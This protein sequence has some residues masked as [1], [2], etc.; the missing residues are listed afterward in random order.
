M[1]LPLS[2]SAPT[3]GV[4]VL[5]LARFST[6][7]QRSSG[8]FLRRCFTPAELSQCQGRL[9]SLAGRWAAKEAVIKCLSAGRQVYRR[10]IE[11]LTDSSGAPQLLLD[12]RPSAI[13][14][15]ISHH[16]D[17][18]VAVALAAASTLL[19]DPPA[20]LHLPQ[21]PADAHKGSFGTVVA[22]AGSMGYTG[23]AHLCATAAA[24]AGAGLVRLLVAESLHGILAAKCTEVMA[25][26]VP[27]VLPGVIGQVSL[28]AMMRHLPSAA[29]AVVGPGLGQDTSTRRAVAELAQAIACPTVL[30]ADALNAL[31]HQA[32]SLGRW[33]GPRVLTPHP[34][35]MARLTGLTVQQ[36]QAD[37]SEIA[38]RYARQWAAV[39]ALKG[40]NT[41][42]ARPDGEVWVD[43]HS[44]PALASAG[45]GD[46]LAGLIAGL[47]AQGC[48]PWQAAVTGVFVHA[49]AGRWASLVMG[50][51][52]VLASD[53]LELIPR[54]MRAARM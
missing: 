24:R 46:V 2:D 32:K 52:G 39:V 37:R 28:G 5:S 4:D 21:R 1:V 51:S 36:I 26:P 13:S 42:V 27:E 25:T 48:D 20:A 15:S 19:A 18:V 23:A 47:M 38:F 40:A 53:L 49:E 22:I 16:G 6:V 7:L 45:S 31:S 9:E 50:D 30:D 34:G 12:G 3:I 29:A 11:V 17:M 43:S 41:V 54:V 33:A 44:V 14:V 35:E 10:Q 8:R